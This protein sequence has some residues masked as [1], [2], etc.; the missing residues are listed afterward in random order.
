MELYQQI[1][2]ML[3]KGK[4]RDV[5]ALVQ[6]AI[7]AGLPAQEILE[8]G[9]MHGMNIIGEKFT[10]NE[11]FVPEVLVS[12]RAMN[13]GSALLKPLLAAD[14]VKAS[15][16]VCIGTVQGDLHDI[17]KNL[18]KLM[19][20]AK[21]LEVI[22]LGNDVSPETFAQTAKEQNCQIICCSALLTT[23]MGI[24]DDVV[25]AAEEAGIRNQ[26]KI[27]IGGAAI[28]AEFCKS[29]GA[30]VYTPDAASAADMA[31]KLCQQG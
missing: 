20:E 25:K 15:G 10:K 1:S 27:M 3:Q 12:A 18:V 30:D 9:L 4:A 8:K 26:V 16:R 11:V 23:T 19:M 6:Q 29:I 7:D 13:M 2:E 24:M 31:V 5:K 21:G 22:D 17:G 14:G 28:S